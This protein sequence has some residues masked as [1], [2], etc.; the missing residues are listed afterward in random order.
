MHR[1]LRIMVTAVLV[2]ALA[3]GVFLAVRDSAPSA[4]AATTT[5]TTT[6]M[7]TTTS[8][9]PSTTT[10]STPA[11]FSAFY[12]DVG[13]SASL[14]MQPTGVLHHNGR[15]TNTGYA[16]DLLYIEALQGVTLSLHQIG[17]PAETVQSILNTTQADHCYTLPKTQMT[18]A[19]AFLRSNEGEAGVVSIDLGF[20]N[21][22]IC[23]SASAVNEA[24]VAA[25]VAA[26]SVDMPKVI[27]D[28][29]SA[30]GRHVRFV[31]VEYSDPFLA[32]YLDGPNGPAVATASLEAVD[33]L[34]AALGKAFGAGGVAVA[35][36]PGLFE[37]DNT[38]RVSMQNVGE[39]PAN[40]QKACELTW[41]CDPAPFGPDDH[42]NDAGYSLIAQ[43][44]AAT[45]PKSW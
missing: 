6:T 15:R 38:T 3:S 40:V 1:R 13:A 32:Y 39:I 31:G 30:A 36:V 21:M 12:L 11:K 41:M 14:G 22:R 16:N 45:L 25:A 20:N 18:Q 37:T 27:K 43:A 5:T 26:V 42:P 33:S 29:K 7:T 9:T 44:I 34:N 23:M 24:C 17:C 2:V 35:N 28:L 19:I 10:T 4:S 8:S